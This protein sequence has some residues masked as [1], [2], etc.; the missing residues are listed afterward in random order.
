VSEKR[1]AGLIEGEADYV[2]VE[3]PYWLL[4]DLERQAEAAMDA[5]E[6][7]DPIIAAGILNVPIH[8]HHYGVTSTAVVCRRWI[9]AED[10]YCD[11]SIPFA[12]VL[13]RRQVT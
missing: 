7:G 12:D 2:H 4:D 5:S 6:S 8:E 3:R 13:D 11:V 10:R 9:A 1:D